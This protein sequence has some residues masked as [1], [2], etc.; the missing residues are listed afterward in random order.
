MHT[1]RVTNA[2]R[3]LV[4]ENEEQSEIIE[5]A[6]RHLPLVVSVSASFA[7]AFKVLRVS[8]LSTTTALEVLRSAGVF[9]VLSAVA[10]TLLPVIPI[11]AALFYFSVR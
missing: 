3:D 8:A 6:V 7:F 11:Y 4:R 5:F 1:P 9:Q 10:L 2:D